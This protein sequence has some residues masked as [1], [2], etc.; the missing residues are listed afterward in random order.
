MDF[1]QPEPVE[2]YLPE[3]EPRGCVLV[4]SDLQGFHVTHAAALCLAGYAVYTALTC[5]D[6]PRVYEALGVAHIDLVA[7]VSLGH[8]G[9]GETAEE[10]APDMP[11]HTDAKWQSNSILQAVDT[12]SFIQQAPPKV[13]LA[14]DLISQDCISI[15]RD[16]LKAAGIHVDTYSARNAFS[17][18]GFLLG[19]T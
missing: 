18:V 10:R 5:T 14:T 1:L 15:S 7:F 13:F 4:V 3:G 9:H 6:V 19:A 16:A 11:T 17:I 12:V 8:G 2:E